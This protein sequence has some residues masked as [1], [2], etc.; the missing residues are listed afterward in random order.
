MSMKS[1]VP[2]IEPMV[3]LF[4]T[5]LGNALRSDDP[6]RELRRRL[7]AEA[8]REEA[9]AAARAVLQKAKR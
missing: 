9:E 6:E 2:L 7:E 4:V 1:F 8:A 3:R 5:I